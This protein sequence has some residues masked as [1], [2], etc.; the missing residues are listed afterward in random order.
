MLRKI[1]YI[2]M[3]VDGSLTDGRLYI[4]NEGELFKAFNVKDGCGIHDIMIPKGIE[5]IIITGRQSQIVENR[6]RELGITRIYQG[7]RDKV[8]KLQELIIDKDL[9]SAAYFGDDI[10]DLDCMRSI[11]AA[12]GI[13]GCPAD[14][15]DEVKNIADFISSQK[16]GNGALREFVEWIIY[17]KPVYDDEAASLQV[18]L[19]M[20]FIFILFAF[21]KFIAKRLCTTKY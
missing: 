4:G 11:Q 17:D 2:I 7:V 20:A 15:V 18:F 8:A 1:K 16:G 21:A 3:D 19:V 10:N 6:C 14:A 9:N 12:G 5:P 13:V